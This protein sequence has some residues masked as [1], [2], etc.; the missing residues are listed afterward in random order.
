MAKAEGKTS[1]GE[2]GVLLL[3]CGNWM[4]SVNETSDE[5]TWA[6]MP[7]YKLAWTERRSF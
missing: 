7:H 2:S 3:N 4:G 6:W 1:I 5:G